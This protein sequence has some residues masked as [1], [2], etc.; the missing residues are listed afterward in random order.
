M[1][2]KDDA[3]YVVRPCGSC[4]SQ[5]EFVSI[6]CALLLKGQV[7]EQTGDITSRAKKRKGDLF[8][9]SRA[10]IVNSKGALSMKYQ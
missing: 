7:S 4:K 8:P 3:S 2:T 9:N 6:Y 1:T 5:I 10:G